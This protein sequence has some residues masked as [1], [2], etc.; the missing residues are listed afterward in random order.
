MILKGKLFSESPIY[1]GNARKTLFTRDGDGKHK[2]VSLAGEVKGT[3]Q[4]LMDAFV[5]QSRDGKN[6]GLI[7]RVWLRLYGS[8]MPENLISKVDC[9]LQKESYPKNNFFDLRMGIKLDEDRWAVEANANY[10]LETVLKNSVFDFTLTVNDPLL[11]KGDNEA[12][13]FNVLEEL[14]EGR[15]WFGAGKSKGL[16]R[17]RLEMSHGMS[18]AKKLPVSP[19]INHCT[20]EFAINAENPVLVGWSWGK[21]DP[22]TPSF[23]SVEGRFLI[24][25]MRNIPKPLRER[26][27]MTMG[28]PILNP[29]DWK[30]KFTEYLPRIISIWLKEKSLG[31]SEAYVL[32]LAS[33]NKLGKGK[34]ALSKKLINKIKPY[35][36][37]PFLNLEEPETGIKEAL[38]KKA[39][40]ARRIMS[41]FEKKSETRKELNKDAWAQVADGMGFDRDMAEDLDAIIQ[42]EPAMIKAMTP[43]CQKVLPRLFEQVDQQ[44]KLLQSD[45][46]VDEEIRKREEHLAVKIMLRDGK[47]SEYQWNDPGM[48]PEGIRPAT[49]REFLEAHKR[50][51]YRHMQS[52]ES[53]KKSIVNDQNQIDFL[54][55][56][57]DG[58]RHELAKTEHTDFRAGGKS[59]RE[60]S[61]KYGKP[62]DT[63]FMRM[64]SWSLSKK[65]KCS[66]ECYIPGATLK[67]AF[68]KRASQILKTLWGESRNTSDVLGK[69]FGEQRKRGMIFFSDAYLSDP[70]NPGN[71]WCSMDGI[72]IDQKT[73]QPVETSKRDYLFAYGNNF[74]FRFRIDIQDIQQTDLQA[75]SVLIHL[76]QDFKRGDIPVGGSKTSGFG[77]VESSISRLTWLSTTAS[78]VYQK[79]FGKVPLQKHGIWEK[80]E[81]EGEEADQVLQPIFSVKPEKGTDSRT[82]PS[83]REGFI[84]HKAFGGY[85]GILAIE[86]ELLTP[87]HVKESGEPSFKTKLENEPVNGWDFFSMAPPEASRR[88]TDKI[89]AV[90][91][92][93]IKGIL[94]SIYSIASDSAVESPDISKLNPSDSL[95]GWVGSGQNQALMGRLSFST[96]TF[97]DS[98]LTWHKA[99]YPYGEWEF[100]NGKWD[101]NPGGSV[102]M[103]HISDKWRIFTHAPLAPIIKQQEGFEPDTV[104]ASYFRAMMPGSR[105]IFS[106]RFWNLLEEELQRLLWCIQ[107]DTGSAH[108]IGNHKHVGFGSMRLKIMPDSFLIDWEKRYSGQPEEKW[109]RSIDVKKLINTSVIKHYK[110]LQELMNAGSL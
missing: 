66:W 49:W 27:E 45:A 75:I 1:R 73:G 103:M 47:L 92:R 2:L 60:I 23:V 97:T 48:A 41:E 104:Q 16:G 72:M 56:Y 15:F 32:P 62:Y 74:E 88:E 43:A 94:R 25:A 81:L 79:I 99:P 100:K 36:D 78:E 102:Q 7:N 84:S 21:I 12:M 67:G 57:R 42:D 63:V 50:V 54:K 69:L 4:S 3:A 91:G 110:K 19:N 77:W 8:H 106:I 13:L 35:A 71:P 101:N 9:K 38:G 33:L 26:I 76:I 28:G 80:L 98:S 93:S 65:D 18:G 40:M 89:Y 83:A 10:K 95:F 87:T 108:K 44:I 105:F 5:G 39:N 61:R 31:E 82:P 96:A 58:T 85:C 53:L 51:R 11:K 22:D 29:D 46:W 20:L 109:R 52:G 64:M 59:N 55:S 24:Q 6:I 17:V 107:L 14:R 70:H 90:P 34:N 86:G 30:Q 68:R 37:K